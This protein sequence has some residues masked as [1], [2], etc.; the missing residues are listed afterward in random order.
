MLFAFVSDNDMVVNGI[1][2]MK[3][4]GCKSRHP[5]NFHRSLATKKEICETILFFFT[6]GLGSEIYVTNRPEF[7]FITKVAS[8]VKKK[9][10]LGGNSA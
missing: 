8:Q 1:D 3:S 2:L 4:L 7:D 10:D 9:E 6:R 5:A